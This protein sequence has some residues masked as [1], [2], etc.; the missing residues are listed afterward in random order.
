MAAKQDI[1]RVITS[2]RRTLDVSISNRAMR[3][4]G[5]EAVVIIKRR[6]RLGYGVVGGLFGN[7][8][9]LRT[10]KPH[11]PQYQEYRRRHRR[12]LFHETSP[13]KQ[14]LTF[15]GELL[16]SLKVKRT[17]KNRAL[18]GFP[19]K[20]HKKSG[21]LLTK[22]AQK[23]HDAGRTFMFLTKKETNQLLKFYRNNFGDLLKKRKI[24]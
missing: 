8:Q 6:T 21:E 19:K 2:I 3:A 11:T 13:R 22:I 23:Q 18:L 7:R 4:I 9:S 24:V 5:R 12:E 1:S 17:R 20:R 15:T 10:M 14:N 16:N